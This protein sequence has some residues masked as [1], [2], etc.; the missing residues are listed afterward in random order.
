MQICMGLWAGLNLEKVYLP[1]IAK[2]SCL[3]SVFFCNELRHH[4]LSTG[5][6]NILRRRSTVRVKA[7]LFFWTR[8]PDSLLVVE[9]LGT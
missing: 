1:V 3:Q 4:L 6:E 7:E 2:Q 5:F 9:K 8:C